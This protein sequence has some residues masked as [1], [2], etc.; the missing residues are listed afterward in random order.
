MKTPFI[1]LALTTSLL[2]KESTYTPLKADTQVTT[3][4]TSF[5]YSGRKVPL[6][7]YFP[8]TQKPSPLILLSHGLGGSRESGT[9][10]GTRWASAG[11]TVV[12][13]QHA[14]SDDSTWRHL[15]ASQR[16]EALKQAASL[17]SFIQRVKDVPATL[18]QLE[19]WNSQ[20][21]HPLAHRM[22]LQNIGIAGHSF[23]ALTTQALVGQSYG[24]FGPCFV[25]QRIAAGFAMSPGIDR[26]GNLEMAFSH[27]AV[28]MLLMTG[29]QDQNFISNA[30]PKTRLEVY[31]H[32]SILKKDSH[33]RHYQLIL[34]DAQHGAF[35]DHSTPGEKKQKPAHHHIIK[36]ISTS[37]WDSVLKNSPK[38]STWLNGQSPAKI[39]AKDDI[40]EKK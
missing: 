4:L 19:K 8:N 27:I 20:D 37:F 40:W 14:G 33:T 30:S 6:K 22:D 7:I 38:A 16:Q 5:S 21:G 36:T 3:K 24:K 25:D 35:S 23:G 13:M 2:A 11:Y 10:L 17:Q 1:L 32:L 28:P 18:D 9:Y 34:K 12:A 39:L 26:I 15:P 31:N 29:T